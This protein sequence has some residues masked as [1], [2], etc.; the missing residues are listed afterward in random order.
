[1]KI[2]SFK[3][4]LPAM[5]ITAAACSSNDAGY[6]INGTVDDCQNGTVYLKE[7][8]GKNFV[9]VD[10]ATVSNGKFK[11]TGTVTEPGAYALTTDNSKRR[12]AIFFL[13]NKDM[14]VTINDA[15]NLI[16]VQGSPL[17]A[18]YY[19]NIDIIGNDDYDIDS[20][21]TSTPDSPVAAYFLIK[22][23]AWRLDL[24]QMKAERAKFDKSLEGSKY[25]SQIDTL[26]KNLS[27]VQV[28]AIAPDFTLNDT[29]GKPVSLNSFKGKYVL[30]DFWA[31]WCPDCRKE[32]PN[33]VKAYGMFKDKNIAF[34]GVSLDR[35]REQW[36]K[37]IEKDSLTWTHVTDLKDW[38]SEVAQ[39]YAVRWIP[40][41]FLIDPN[42]VIIARSLEG[43]ALINKLSEVLE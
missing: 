19:A 21:I 36:L 33:V 1:M 32:N 18:Q 22:E 41:N 11:L 8:V 13:E 12:P 15:A 9:T 35:S 28:G 23:F 38:N 17:T 14:Q 29:E 25:V 6:Q 2:L 26:I 27:A 31:S 5:A 7:S 39:K 30:I 42:G 24:E 16:S 34:L 37:A 43:D 20:L 40:Q 3:T 4:I 10:S